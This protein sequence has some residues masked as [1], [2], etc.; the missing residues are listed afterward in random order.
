MPLTASNAIANDVGR[1][2]LLTRLLAGIEALIL[3]GVLYLV[4]SVRNQELS[5]TELKASMS[6]SQQAMAAVPALTIRVVEAEKD[7]AQ[8][9]T[10]I[11]EVK[12]DV[13]ELRAR[14]R[15]E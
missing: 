13:K 8:N 3:A 9:K 4:S 1:P 15:L 12:E 14:A 2:T 10:D 11:H 7:I 6:A 5:M